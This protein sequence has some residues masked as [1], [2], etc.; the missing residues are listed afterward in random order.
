[1][2][3]VSSYL[4][5]EGRRHGHTLAEF[6][7]TDGPVKPYHWIV[8]CHRDLEQDEGVVNVS[9]GGAV[10]AFDVQLSGNTSLPSLSKADAAALASDF[11]ST[12][13]PRVAAFNLSLISHSLQSAVPSQRQDH[14]LIYE[15]AAFKVVDAPFRVQVRIGGDRVVGF[16][17]FFHVPPSHARRMKNLRSFN[18]T[19]A[20]LANAA[21][22]AIIGL[23]ATVGL[24]HL[25]RTR[26]LNVPFALSASAVLVA[27]NYAAILNHLEML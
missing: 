7:R 15:D 22:Y 24:R 18:A 10:V 14:L 8:R 25:L 19:I 21:F 20:A 3:F 5:H 9:P 27:V 2:G 23:A 4:D 26:S 16:E 12:R 1:P 17:P 6:A 13:F 11:I